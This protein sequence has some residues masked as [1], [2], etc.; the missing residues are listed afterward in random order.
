LR[1]EL[2]PTSAVDAT[3]A[4]GDARL[5]LMV[6]EH[7]DTVW[8]VVRGLGVPAGESGRRGAEGPPRRRAEAAGDRGGRRKTMLA[9]RR[10]GCT[11]CPLPVAEV[12]LGAMDP[13]QGRP[14]DSPPRPS[15]R[16]KPWSYSQGSSTRW[17]NAFVRFELEEMS[18]VD[19]ARVLKIPVGT[20]ASR[21]RRAREHTR[22][23]PE[24]GRR[25]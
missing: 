5:R 21:V 24:A 22:K 11:P 15:N 12:P 6:D 3:V 9:R 13:C 1:F 25:S 16:S 10:V 8:R 20:V 2:A 7:F 4:T 19:V 23:S 17:R 18:A 14:R